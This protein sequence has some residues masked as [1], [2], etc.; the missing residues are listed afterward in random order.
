MKVFGKMA[1]DL[2]AM[3]GKKTHTVLYPQVKAEVP[4]RFRGALAF[5]PEKCVGCKLCM[6]VCP[7]NAIVIEPVPD[8]EKVF[9][10]RV[11]MDKCIFCG[12][13]VD[14]CNKNSLRSTHRF[15]LATGDKASMDEE[16]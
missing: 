7:A 11:Q 12:Q 3:L 10:C 1:P 9:R 2:L 14:S 4:E 5:D 16:I 15:E 13:C 8:K 6:R